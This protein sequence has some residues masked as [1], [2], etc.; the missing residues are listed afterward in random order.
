MLEFALGM[1]VGSL[2]VVG[3]N[4]LYRSYQNYRQGQ[5]WKTAGKEWKSTLQKMEDIGMHSVEFGG[6]LVEEAREGAFRE[7]NKMP[8]DETKEH[9]KRIAMAEFQYEANKDRQLKIDEVRTEKIKARRQKRIEADER[10]TEERL[11]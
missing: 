6:K 1:F 10:L 5:L 2:V 8:D 3:S 4:R 9:Q 11:T 7:D